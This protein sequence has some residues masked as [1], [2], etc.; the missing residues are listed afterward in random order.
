APYVQHEPAY[1]DH[2][3]ADV[4]RLPHLPP[5]H[6][7]ARSGGCPVQ[8][9]ALRPIRYLRAG[10]TL[11]WRASVPPVVSPFLQLTSR[12]VV[13]TVDSYGYLQRMGSPAACVLILDRRDRLHSAHSVPSNPVQCPEQTR[14]DCGS[15]DAP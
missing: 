13:Q 10:I 6:R 12:L 7:S 8:A 9:M 1:P 5:L 11:R 3:P 2:R 14:V 4:K 15:Y